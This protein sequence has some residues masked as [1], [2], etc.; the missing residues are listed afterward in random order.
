MRILLTGAGGPA[1]IG[2]ARSL[3]LAGHKLTGVDSNR[4][5][6]PF[7]RTHSKHLVPRCDHLS[8]LDAIRRI[9][10]EESIDFIH[11]QPDPE[12]RVISQYRGVLG[13]RVFL[14]DHETVLLCQDKLAMNRRLLG[15]GVPIPK[16]IP[17]GSPMD[18]DGAVALFGEQFWTRARTGAAGRGSWLSS[19]E[20]IEQTVAW[21]DSQ[22]GWGSFIASEYLPGRL[23]TWQSVW[24]DGQI[25]CAQSR[26]RLEWAMA[27]RAPSG[28]TGVTGVART[29]SRSDVAE[30][31][32]RCVRALEE[33]PN[34]IFGVDM[35][36]DAK[37]VP[38]VTEVNIGRFFTTIEFFTQLG[39]NMPD[40]YV[41][42]A[43]WE[44]TEWQPCEDDWYWLRSMDAEPRLVP[45]S[46]FPK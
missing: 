42:A 13:A 35:K 6:L 38:R 36:E 34:G 16:T 10:E 12:V 1:G 32:E 29:I 45:G 41:R 15:T 19:T 24:R 7:A 25:V 27:N 17:L 37:G 18:I 8:Y 30:V 5:A 44:K 31:G 43:F 26:E 21:V 28:V 46:D 33:R 4:Y 20:H 22:H 3:E 39:L 40:L 2:V 9:V 14:P 23:V 11:A